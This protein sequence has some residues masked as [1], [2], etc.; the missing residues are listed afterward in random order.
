MSGLAV[1]NLLSAASNMAHMA[2]GESDSAAMRRGVSGQGTRGQRIGGRSAE[3][4]G[5]RGERRENWTGTLAGGVGWPYAWPDT[6]AGG[7]PRGEGP[8]N[9]PGILAG[10]GHLVCV[11][12]D[13]GLHDGLR[14]CLHDGLRLSLRDASPCPGAT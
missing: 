5:L 14:V 2:N 7:V 9:W 8:E 4:R 13:F 1:T 10:G 3:R 11:R 6:L 12:G